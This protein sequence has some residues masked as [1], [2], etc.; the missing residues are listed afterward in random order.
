MKKKPA[1]VS[2]TMGFF[3]FFILLWMG[4]GA[5][6]AVNLHPALPDVPL[7]KS[8]M[9]AGSFLVA[10]VLFILWFFLKKKNRWAYYFS[11]GAFGVSILTTFLDNVGWADLIFLGLCSVMLFLLLKDRKWYLEEKLRL[12][13]N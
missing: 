13:V 4:F 9:A 3:L 8:I 5:I 1:S 7:V 10:A 6:V 2:I 12:G 11:L